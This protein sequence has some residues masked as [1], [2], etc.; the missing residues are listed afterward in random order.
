M[1]EAITLLSS[2]GLRVVMG[3][4]TIAQYHQF[5]G[6]DAFRAA[7]MQRFL[8]D[9]D[10]KAIIAARG[11][12]GTIRMIDMLDFSRFTERPKWIIGFSDI[13]LLHTHILTNF[14]TQS[15][16]GQ[17]PISMADSSPAALESLRKC[18]FGEPLS[19][20]I[21]P[22][23]LNRIGQAEGIL[24]GG[25]LSLLIA[26]SGS[27]SDLDYADKILFIEDVGEYLYALDRMLYSLKRAGKLKHLRG[28]IVGAFSQ[29][30]DNDI[31]FGQSPEEIIAA[32]VSEYD[33]PV[34]FGF[35]AGHVPDNQAMLFGRTICLT[36]DTDKSTIQYL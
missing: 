23:P 20:P 1:A 10:V 24:T 8:D 33:Y 2:W 31:P 9:D 17:M 11:G 25:N 6:D 15:I 4:T 26:A 21:A 16:H 13:T 29:M 5:A 35:P 34:C 19:Y 28:L 18:L 7:D 3:E 32:I 27:V 30:K 12:Y 22:Q 36:V 14:N